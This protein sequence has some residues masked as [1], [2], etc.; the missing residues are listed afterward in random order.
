MGL[1]CELLYTSYLP[2]TAGGFAVKLLGY[3]YLLPACGRRTASVPVLSSKSE[4]RHDEGG[5]TQTS[6][7]I[8]SFISPKGI[9]YT[10]NTVV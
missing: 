5:S 7:V 9:T 10:H 8:Y 4:Q 2:T 3:R 6:H 1:P